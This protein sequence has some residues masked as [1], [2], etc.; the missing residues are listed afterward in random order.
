MTDAAD[1]EREGAISE[2]FA[3]E[4]WHLSE[5][6]LWIAY[7]DA[8]AMMDRL[9]PST[10]AERWKR[11]GAGTVI[12]E[13]TLGAR[14]LGIEPNPAD[15]LATTLLGGGVRASGRLVENGI[16][17]LRSSIPESQWE[18]FELTD[19][20]SGQDATT[21]YPRR[22]TRGGAAPAILWTDILFDRES[23]LQVFPPIV[24]RAT[25]KAATD[26]ERALR[27]LAEAYQK[28]PAD[29]VVG[30]VWREK[31]VETFGISA[32]QAKSVWSKVALDF[33]VLSQLRG[34]PHVRPGR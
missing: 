6:L 33:P 31:A 24:R 17:A 9:S 34:K 19:G 7:R 28:N 15:R 20:A 2:L 21:A 22:H 26:A 27:Q 30:T 12:A 8:S 32:R 13:I 11:T 4:R 10:H 25:V 14:R 16:A 3:K 1:R 18:D 29:A 5:T 23:V